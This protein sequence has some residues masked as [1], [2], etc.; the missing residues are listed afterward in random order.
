MTEGIDSFTFYTS[1]FTGE[2]NFRLPSGI[3]Q[4]SLEFEN[5]NLFIIEPDEFQF[6][7]PG[8]MGSISQDFC[9]IPRDEVADLSIHLWPADRAAPGF[10]V[11]YTIRIR[12]NGTADRAARTELFFDNETVTFVD[13]PLAPTSIEPGKLTWDIAEL[14]ILS[15]LDIP[16]SLIHI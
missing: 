13:S 12:N 11:D 16:L 8:S 9:L 5:Q 10:E 3:Y 7:F 14:Q 2:F 6:E 1:P 15:E 4:T